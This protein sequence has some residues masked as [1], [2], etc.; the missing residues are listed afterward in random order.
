[1]LPSGGR[2]SAATTNVGNSTMLVPA[3]A[4]RSDAAGST[5]TNLRCAGP[6][7]LRSG[8]SS[9]H[10]DSIGANSPAAAAAFRVPSK[11]SACSTWRDRGMSS[12]ALRKSTTDGTSGEDVEECDDPAFPDSIEGTSAPRWKENTNRQCQSIVLLWLRYMVLFSRRLDNSAGM[13]ESQTP[14]NLACRCNCTRNGGSIGLL[15]WMP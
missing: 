1:M 14:R 7:L 11:A 2:G 4:D 6:P 12:L 10:Q 13:M 5:R 15:G 9:I 8:T 3:S